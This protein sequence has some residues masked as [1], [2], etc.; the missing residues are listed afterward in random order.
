MD[1]QGRGRG[2]VPIEAVTVFS[3]DKQ[4]LLLAEKSAIDAV[5][6]VYNL[7]LAPWLKLDP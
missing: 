6:C 1:I 5:Q 7:E 2:Y 4:E 3:D